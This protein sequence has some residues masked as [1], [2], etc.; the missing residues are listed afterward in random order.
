MSF[1]PDTYWDANGPQIATQTISVEHQAVEERLRALLPSLNVSSV[2]DVGCGQ[3]RVAK[4]LKAVLPDAEYS[5]LDLGASQIAG[6]RKIRPDGTFYHSRIQDFEPDR[7]WDL[8]LSSE[9][10]MHVPPADMP[11][12]AKMLKAAASKYVLLIEWIPDP[13]ELTEPIAPWNWPHDYDAL[14]GPFIHRERIYRQDLM[15]SGT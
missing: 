8:V 15:L 10:L 11:A 4:L 12:A 1:D 5:G 9:V 14:F 13:W 2:L 7:R 3:G 6:T